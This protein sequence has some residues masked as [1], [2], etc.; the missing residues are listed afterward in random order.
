MTTNEKGHMKGKD[1]AREED[2]FSEE[3]NFR[4]TDSSREESIMGEEIEERRVWKECKSRWSP[5]H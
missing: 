1:S 5:Y 2:T 3:D 4:G